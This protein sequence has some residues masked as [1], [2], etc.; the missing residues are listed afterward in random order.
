MGLAYGSRVS[1]SIRARRQAPSRARL[2]VLLEQDVISVLAVDC[3][4]DNW[5]DADTR[6]S[7]TNV[8]TARAALAALRVMQFDLMVTQTAVAGEPVW[9]LAAKVRAMRPRVRWVLVS[10]ML[11]PLDEITARTLGVSAILEHVASVVGYPP[12]TRHNAF[13]GQRLVPASVASTASR[14][15]VERND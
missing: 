13:D 5:D 12:T 1:G 7:V 14:F 2:N 10:P 9:E 4:L 6:L 3:P 15:A 8:T 11:S